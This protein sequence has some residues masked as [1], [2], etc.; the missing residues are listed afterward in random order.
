MQ[1]Q[2]EGVWSWQLVL[3]DGLPSPSPSTSSQPPPAPT[4]YSSAS[5]PALNTIINNEITNNS[6]K[7]NIVIAYPYVRLRVIDN[8]SLEEFPSV[9]GCTPPRYSLYFLKNQLKMI[10]FLILNY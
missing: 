10:I 8:D 6:I 3:P 5:S 7:T 2:E 4:L 9:L 1:V